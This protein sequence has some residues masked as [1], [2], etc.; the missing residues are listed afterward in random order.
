MSFSPNLKKKKRRIVAFVD[1]DDDCQQRDGQQASVEN[2][3]E[4]PHLD[5]ESSDEDEIEKAYRVLDVVVVDDTEVSDSEEDESEDECQ[6]TQ[7]DLF[8]DPDDDNESL[9]TDGES[10]EDDDE[11]D[12][13]DD[14][15]DEVAVLSPPST[16][17]A[18]S[19]Q[20]SG[21]SRTVVH[22]TVASYFDVPVSLMSPEQRRKYNRVAADR[23]FHMKKNPE[24]PWE[25]VEKNRTYIR[26]A[27]DEERLIANRESSKLSYHRPPGPNSKYGSS[28]EKKIAQRE[29]S[30]AS[31]LRFRERQKQIGQF[32]RPRTRPGLVLK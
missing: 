17:S 20:R 1:S 28:K 11:E 3:P 9:L 24:I 30:R 18:G 26:R 16:S 14:D 15:D 7:V 27:N 4:R 31:S 22:R 6:G 21:A 23:G 12:D 10:E 2:S 8:D 29:Q 25:Y 32:N 19:L 5:L 13:D